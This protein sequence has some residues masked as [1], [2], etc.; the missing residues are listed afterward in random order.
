MT[1]VQTC[2]LPIFYWFLSRNSKFTPQGLEISFGKGRSAHTVRDFA[3]T[4]EVLK[5]LMLRTKKHTFLVK[6]LDYGTNEWL[7]V[8]C[9]FKKGRPYTNTICLG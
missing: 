2:A 8:P 6:D 9:D 4:I 1:G 3:V 7:R 5:K